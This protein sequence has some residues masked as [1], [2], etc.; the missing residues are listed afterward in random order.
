MIP[1][2]Y[3]PHGVGI[4]TNRGSEFGIRDEGIRGS[5]FG[6]RDEGDWASRGIFVLPNLGVRSSG[7]ETKGFGVRGSRRRGLGFERDFRLTES[8]ASEFGV[9][10]L[11]F[12]CDSNS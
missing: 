1:C 11:G 9:R 5:E 4:D 8:R 2:Q 12:E 6:V 10:G 7:F 3:V